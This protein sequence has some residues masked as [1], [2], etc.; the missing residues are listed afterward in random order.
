LHA[1]NVNAGTFTSSGVTFNEFGQDGANAEGWSTT[2]TLDPA[3]YFEVTIAPNAGYSLTISDINFDY[4]ASITGPASFQL[5]YSKQSNFASPTILVTKTDVN[6]TEKISSNSGLS[7]QINS[8]ETLTLRWFGYAFNAN[9]NE[10]RIKNL[11]ILGTVTEIT[12]T[13]DDP[14]KIQECKSIGNEPANLKIK[15][16]D[17]KNNGFSNEVFG[18]DDEWFHLEEIEVEIQLENKGDEKIKD[19]EVQWGVYNVDTDEWVIELDDEK[20]FD[21]KKDSD[22]TLTV[23]FKLDDDMD[24]DL[25]DLSDGDTLRF[26][27]IATGEDNEVDDDVCT[28]DSEEVEMIVEDDWV[29]LDNLQLPETAQCGSEVQITADLWNI[30][31]E[32]Q[33]DVLLTIRNEELGINEIVDI[34][35]IDA[36]DDKRVDVL[37]NIPEDADEK[38]YLIEFKVLDE[39]D[40]IYENDYDEDEAIFLESLKVQGNC[41]GTGDV[42]FSANLE[43]EAREQQEMT[44]NVNMKNVGTETTSYTILLSGLESWAAEKEVTPNSFTLAPGESKDIKVVLVPNAGSKGDQTFTIKAF[45]G[46]KIAEQ[47]V[48]VNVQEA[49]G[50][51]LTGLSISESFKE[52]WFIWAI[53]A[54]NII[55]IIL[56]IVVAT[57]MSGGP[58]A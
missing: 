12:S 48:S 25:E 28:Y 24:V 14:E 8:G 16:I 29:V 54:V 17:I 10:F 49:A 40:E 21:L 52:N 38:S 56:I 46:G 45:Y 53:V 39:N 27:V 13:S 2:S 34:G 11:N 42:E 30:G 31:S 33:E 55:L 18:E 36:F 26:Y 47:E 43:S 15:D 4:S 20:D 37:V 19:I 57:R 44:I 32:D 9:T 23:S 7:I 1:A 22:K 51:G 58:R 6:T 35:D 50:F 5:Q 41:A 3:K